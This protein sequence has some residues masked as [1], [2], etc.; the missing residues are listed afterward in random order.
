MKQTAI[1][2]LGPIFRAALPG[3][4][5]PTQPLGKFL[6]EMAMGKWEDKLAEPG[7]EKLGEF[8]IVGNAAFRRLSGLDT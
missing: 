3:R 6:A 5:S 8:C 4:C 1:A 2:V 7:F